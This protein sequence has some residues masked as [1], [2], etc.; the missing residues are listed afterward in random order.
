MSCWLY[1]ASCF[2]PQ[3]REITS[4]LYGIFHYPVTGRVQDA[5]S[6]WYTIA[7]SFEC[8]C[9]NLTPRGLQRPEQDPFQV[10]HLRSYYHHLA[11]VEKYLLA[12][13]NRS[14]RLPRGI[15]QLMSILP[16][17]S[18]LLSNFC[19]IQSYQPT[20]SHTRPVAVADYWHR[21]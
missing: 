14:R 9:T 13:E 17:W 6:P 3:A 4:R 8:L 16:S 7:F 15:P 11:A 20:A 21:R 5:V 12:T 2:W 1:R 10:L 19:Q 18:S